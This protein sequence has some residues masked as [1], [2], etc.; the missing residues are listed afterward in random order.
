[1]KQSA[2]GF[3]LHPFTL[4]QIKLNNLSHVGY[5]QHCNENYSNKETKSIQH[6]FYFI[7][8]YIKLN[9]FSANYISILGSKHF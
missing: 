7:I 5:S 3:I 9:Y 2:D 1:V 4:D 6:Y 8:K